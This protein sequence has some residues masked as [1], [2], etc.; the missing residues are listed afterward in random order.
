VTIITVERIFQLNV[1]LK[2]V[3]AFTSV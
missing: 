3:A 2:C 1:L